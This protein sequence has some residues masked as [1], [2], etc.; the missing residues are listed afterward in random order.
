MLTPNAHFVTAWAFLIIGTT[1]CQQRP[2]PRV[3]ELE[4]QVA[5]LRDSLEEVKLTASVLESTVNTLPESIRNT[6]HP[7]SASFDPAKKEFQPV[8][9]GDYGVFLV[10]LE[11]IQPYANGYRVTFN[12]GNP[13]QVSFNGVEMKLRWGPTRPENW[14]EWAEWSKKLQEL[15]QS[16]PNTLRPGSWNPVTVVIAPATAEQIGVIEVTEISTKTVALTR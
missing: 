7:A 8:H 3:A 5:T 15:T 2:D 4:K 14:K 10:S 16:V 13:M 1:A 9:S 11:N 12:L 6:L